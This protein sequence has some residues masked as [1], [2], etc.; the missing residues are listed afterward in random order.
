MIRLRVLMLTWEYPPRIIGGISRH[1]YH[2]TKEFNKLNI[3][4]HIITCWEPN[5]CDYERHGNIFIYRVRPYSIQTQDFI[6]WVFQLNMAMLEHTIRIINQNGYEFD[7]VHVHDWIAAFC[8]R[9][10]KHIYN[11]PLI[12][13]IHA[14]ENGRNNGL[15]NDLQRYISNVEWWA[16]YEAW[17]VIVCSRYMKYELNNFFQLPDDKIKIIPNGIDLE[18]FQ[19]ID[20]KSDMGF[21]RN[22][23]ADD[24]KIILFIGRLVREKG[25]QVLLEA[26]SHLIS[27][28][29][30]CKLIIAGRG[31][32]E[33]NLKQTAT[34]LGIYPNV[35][36]TGYID[37]QTRNRL[38][39]ISDTAVFPS[40]YEPF[41]IVAL[42]GM[43]AGTPVITTDAGGL[44]E[45]IESG[46][47]GIKVPVGDVQALAHAIERVLVDNDYAAALKQQGYIKAK[48]R[49]GWDVI[50]KDTIKVYRQ[51][52]EEDQQIKN[53]HKNNI[54]DINKACHRTV[55][56]HGKYNQ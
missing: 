54:I 45:I 38:Y 3:K 5:C 8:A 34:S 37:D 47:D 17:K 32:F 44:N 55:E 15:H 25:V 21:R 23:A 36:F 46:V 30:K 24:E 9:A 49:Y 42:E 28:N 1:V 50:A 4:T 39:S 40:F 10:L 51:V 52:M 56:Y 53:G 18:D 14:T 26:V 31:P 33:D 29:I 35:Y 19:P 22:Y 7:I 11:I 20:Q 43:A 16:T 41:G 2:L 6:N 12:C 48:T 13:T 27:K